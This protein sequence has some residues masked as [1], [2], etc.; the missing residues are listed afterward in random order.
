M[1]DIL[2][3]KEEL[4]KIEETLSVFSISKA[5]SLYAIRDSFDKLIPECRGINDPYRSSLVLLGTAGA[6]T[7]FHLDWTEAANIAFGVGSKEGVLA[8]WLFLH[9]GLASEADNWLKSNGFPMGFKTPDRVHLI[10]SVRAEFITHM[11][12]IKDGGCILIKQKGGQLVYVPPGWIHQVTNLALCLKV[13]WDFYS[14]KHFHYYAMIQTQ[15][16]KLFGENM[17]EDY[18]AA[19]AIMEV[20]IS[21]LLL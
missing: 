4:I 18:M 16:A 19:N 2:K 11:N 17:V 6:F 12:S 5:A 8:E 21:R 9:P 14:Y 13:A 1:S 10:G 7:G 20:C 3:S 15:I